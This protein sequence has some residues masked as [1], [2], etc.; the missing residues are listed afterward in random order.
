MIPFD[1]RDSP[2][3]LPDNEN[4]P[5]PKAQVTNFVQHM[6]PQVLC[7]ARCSESK[8]GATSAV[9]VNRMTPAKQHPAVH[10]ETGLSVDSAAT[11][12]GMI[13]FPVI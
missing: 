13:R 2:D 11:L 1:G 7:I 6:I 5:D 12:S 8:V 4:H 3:L 9:A 10:S